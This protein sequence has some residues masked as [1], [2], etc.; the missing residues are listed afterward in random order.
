MLSFRSIPPTCQRPPRIMSTGVLHAMFPMACSLGCQHASYDRVL[1]GVLIKKVNSKQSE[2]AILCLLQIHWAVHDALRIWGQ[3]VE[4]VGPS[5][6]TSALHV[7]TLDLAL[8]HISEP[9]RPY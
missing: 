4:A 8:I 7:H 3:E 9:T 6:T 2:L 5:V 1:R